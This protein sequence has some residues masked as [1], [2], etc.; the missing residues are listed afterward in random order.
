MTFD[1]HDG[2]ADATLAGGPPHGVLESAAGG[3]ENDGVMVVVPK[4]VR[5]VVEVMV[6]VE[7]ELVEFELAELA[8]LELAGI[9]SV[10]IEIVE[11]PIIEVGLFSAAGDI[12]VSEPDGAMMLTVAQFMLNSCSLLYQIHANT[13]TPGSRSFGT[14]KSNFWPSGLMLPFLCGQL[15]S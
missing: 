10:E 5:V 15:P 6:V 13:C 12:G 14:V 1:A 7:V 4:V 2:Q 8:E 11:S 9:E 3:A